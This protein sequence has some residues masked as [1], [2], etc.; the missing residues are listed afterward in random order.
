LNRAA[1]LAALLLLTA[2]AEAARWHCARGLI[3][4]VHLH[5]C[6]SRRSPLAHIALHRHHRVRFA[7]LPRRHRRHPLDIMHGDPI[8]D[9]VVAEPPTLPDAFARSRMAPTAPIH[10]QL[11]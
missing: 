11:P 7:R 10:W 4:R 5:Q 6:V 9:R 2:P 8:E 1:L 3:Y